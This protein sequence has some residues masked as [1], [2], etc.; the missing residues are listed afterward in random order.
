MEDS[1]KKYVKKGQIGI[2]SELSYHEYN[3]VKEK[4]IKLYSNDKQIVFIKCTLRAQD[5]E[6]ETEVVKQIAFY[7][8]KGSIHS[9]IQEKHI[10]R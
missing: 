2:Y 4:L 8:I 7:H 9:G 6:E 5:I 10:T 1:F 3:V